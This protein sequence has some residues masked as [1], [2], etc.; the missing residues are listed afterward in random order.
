MGLAYLRPARAHD[1][2]ADAVRGYAAEVSGLRDGGFN[3]PLSDG[4]R[5]S[6]DLTCLA[7]WYAREETAPMAAGLAG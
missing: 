5:L 7:D 4:D 1:G 3:P 6:R 2:D